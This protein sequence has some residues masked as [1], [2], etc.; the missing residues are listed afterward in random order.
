MPHNRTNLVYI[1]SKGSD[2]LFNECKGEYSNP[3]LYRS[4]P[5]YNIWVGCASL[6]MVNSAESYIG[7]LNS[8]FNRSHCVRF[9]ANNL[10]K[11][12]N[13]SLLLAAMS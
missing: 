13:H 7:V 2:E 4:F 1:C 12:R 6:I 3:F 10:E 8:D 5:F 11:D 9:R